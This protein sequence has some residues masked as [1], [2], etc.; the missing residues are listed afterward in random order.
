MILLNAQLMAIPNPAPI[1]PIYKKV[2]TNTQLY[3]GVS[4]AGYI[5]NKTPPEK[6]SRFNVGKELHFSDKED[7]TFYYMRIFIQ[8][9][10]Q[11]AR[12]AKSHPATVQMK[13]NGIV[14]KTY[15]IPPLGNYDRNT[16]LIDIFIPMT[17]KGLYS[18]YLV[19]TGGDE[20]Q[21]SNEHHLFH[22]LDKIPS[23]NHI[24]KK[25]TAAQI[26]AKRLA[27]WYKAHPD[28]KPKKRKVVSP[29]LRRVN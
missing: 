27:E 7:A 2:S 15:L 22:N 28:Q 20:V 29:K 19:T 3:F 23:K 5:S 16:K 25:M 4:S 12:S 13:K 10:N 26:R 18:F 21:N 9:R 8:P 14:V 11:N 24:V 17:N 1:L 6:I